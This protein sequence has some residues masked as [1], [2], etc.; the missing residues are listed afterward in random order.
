MDFYL[1]WKI[2]S[3]DGEQLLITSKTELMYFIYRHDKK[4]RSC[5]RPSVRVWDSLVAPSENTY[6]CVLLNASLG[7]NQPLFPQFWTMPSQ[8]LS[9]YLLHTLKIGSD[10]NAGFYSYSTRYLNYLNR[11]ITAK[12]HVYCPQTCSSPC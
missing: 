7:F 8:P 3:H 6:L 9:T 2:G 12:F 5:D 1:F 11:F 10:Q 4:N